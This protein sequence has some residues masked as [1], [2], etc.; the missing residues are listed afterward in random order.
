[1]PGYRQPSAQQPRR[2]N[3]GALIKVGLFVGAA[4]LA[5]PKDSSGTPMAQQA[6]GGGWL[7]VAQW[8]ARGYLGVKLLEQLDL[9]LPAPLQQSVM[10]APSVQPVLPPPS[11]LLSRAQIELAVDRAMEKL[12]PSAAATLEASL[13]AYTPPIDA[14]WLTL[15]PHPSVILVLGKRGSGKSALRTPR[16]CCSGPS[17]WR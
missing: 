7:E 8:G 4:V 16:C 14:H 12:W 17:P 11:P 15:A 6:Q 3:W 2:V 1:M 13:N 10:P 5:L 9:E